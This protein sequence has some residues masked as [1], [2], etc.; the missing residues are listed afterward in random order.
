MVYDSHGLHHFHRRKRIHQKH[1]K[2]PHPN[3][4]KGIMDKLIFVVGV[5]GPIVTLPQIL[6]IWIEQNATGVSVVSWIAYLILAT[7]WLIYGIMHKEKPIIVAYTGWII[8]ELLVIIGTF[9]YG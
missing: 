6:K 8:A 1:E 2:Y 4:W 9:I 7:F 3:K 5:A